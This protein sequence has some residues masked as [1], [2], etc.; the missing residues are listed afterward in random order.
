MFHRYRGD[1]Q[2]LTFSSDIEGGLVIALKDV[3]SRT[4]G[5]LELV[6]GGTAP[7]DSWWANIRPALAYRRTGS[8]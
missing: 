3:G 2:S 8:T 7:F 1:R 6:A 4:I 5:R